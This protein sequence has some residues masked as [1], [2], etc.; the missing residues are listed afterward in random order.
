MNYIEEKQGELQIKAEYLKKLNALRIQK[1]Q[2][3]NEYKALTQ[4]IIGE[5]KKDYAHSGTKI[6]DYNFIVKGGTYTF[7]FSIEKLQELYPDIYDE[8]LV[9]KLDTISYSLTYAKR[10]K[11]EK[12]TNV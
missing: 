3:D 5:L 4:G 1:N 2:I 12:E 8:C 7:E 6:S 10:E 9:P 11:K